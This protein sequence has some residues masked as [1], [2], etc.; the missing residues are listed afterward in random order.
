ML[1]SLYYFLIFFKFVIVLNIN[2]NSDVFK[3]LT[4]EI[5]I[6]INSSLENSGSYSNKSFIFTPSASANFERFS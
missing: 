4:K 3:F 1:L 2:F 6:F 5:I